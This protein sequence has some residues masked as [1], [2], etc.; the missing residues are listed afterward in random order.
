MF[1]NGL[2][3]ILGHDENSGL[4]AAWSYIDIKVNKRGILS[5]THGTLHQSRLVGLLG[6]SGR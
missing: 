6:P 3:A 1:L 5:M 4:I 2:R